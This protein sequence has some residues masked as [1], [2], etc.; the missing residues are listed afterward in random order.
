MYSSI[1]AQL[2]CENLGAVLELTESRCLRLLKG[3]G[4]GF[5]RVTLAFPLWKL[6]ILIC[7]SDWTLAQG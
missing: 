4:V 5:F 1:I 7:S 2:S 6:S 3:E